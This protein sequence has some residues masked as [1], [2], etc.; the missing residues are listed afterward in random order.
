MT[1]NAGTTSARLAMKNEGGFGDECA[2]A[3][4]PGARELAGPMDR[5][6]KVMVSVAPAFEELLTLY[7]RWTEKESEKQT[8]LH[9]RQYQCCSSL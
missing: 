8:L 1:G 6:T 5:G 4:S 3:L 2:F 7:Q 9:E